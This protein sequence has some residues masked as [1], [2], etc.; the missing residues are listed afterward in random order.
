VNAAVAEAA[1]A[2]QAAKGARTLATL[3]NCQHMLFGALAALLESQPRRAA[4][5]DTSTFDPP[6]DEISADFKKELKKVK[7]EQK[8]LDKA[9]VDVGPRA[10]GGK[11]GDGRL[12]RQL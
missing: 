10:M 8:E 2:I 3:P 11:R 4:R 5:L 6:L 9:G 7:A 12:R 1:S